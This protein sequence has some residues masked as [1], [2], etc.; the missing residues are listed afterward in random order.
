MLTATK[1]LVGGACAAPSP[2]RRR[3][4]VVP[5]ARRKPG[6]G[7]RTSVSKVG[8][9]STTTTTTTTLSTDSNGTAV[10]TVAR[11]DAHV[12]DRTQTTEMKA[13]VT[14]HMSKA[15][16]VRDFL[17]DLIL[18]TWL[19]VDLVSSE[20]DPQTGQEWEPI[21][22]AVKHSGRVDDEWDMY[23]AT[24]K[25]PGSFGPIGAVQVTNYHHSEML[26]GDI[27]V[28]PTGQE[29]SAVTFH[30]NSW[31]DPS[32]CT[33]DKRVFFPARSYLPSQTPKGVEGLR[34]RELEILRGTGC[35]ERKEHDRI[36]DYDVYNDLGNP[37]DKKNPW[38]PSCGSHQRITPPSTSGSTP[39]PGTSPTARPWPGGTCRPRWVA[40]TCA[41]S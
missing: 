19:H 23:E 32:H 30:C 2:A 31:I 34:K 24:F 17:Y 4:F 16:G 39:W 41:H 22:G 6:N 7:R 25:V 40:T 5:E 14:V 15:A 38:R 20:L 27:E 37:D 12:R 13:T 21:S 18:K 8:S 3:T 26:L 28:F 36:Y 33:P 10:G 11:P 29:E 1:S 35:G 9:T